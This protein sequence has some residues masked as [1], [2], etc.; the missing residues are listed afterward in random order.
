ME[1]EWDERKR[2]ETRETRGLDFADLADYDWA[3]ALDIED[4]R[5]YGEE[6]RR[7][8]VGELHGRLMVIVYTLRGD[9]VR[10]ISMRKANNREKKAYDA[11]D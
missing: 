7:I 5:D 2:I 4:V 9:R 10:V 1:L 8:S 3:A 6:R 11:L